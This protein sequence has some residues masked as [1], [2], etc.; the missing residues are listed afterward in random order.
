MRRQKG[1]KRKN[2]LDLS[3][4]TRKK[5]LRR[6]LSVSSRSS[7]SLSC[8][9]C[10]SGW[11]EYERL[12]GRTM[13]RVKERRY[14]GKHKS[15]N[16]RSRYRSRSCSS[17]RGSSRSNSFNNEENMMTEVNSRR[18]R[19]VITFAKEIEEDEE[20]EWVKDGNKEVILCD[21]GDYPSSKS[22]DSLDGGAKELIKCQ[23][24]GSNPNIEHDSNDGGRQELIECEYDGSNPTNDPFEKNNLLM[25]ENRSDVSCAEANLGSD[26][27]ES[28]LRQKALENLRKF[29][30]GNQMNPNVPCDQKYGSANKEDG[31]EVDASTQGADQ[32]SLPKVERKSTFSSQ[33]VGENPIGKQSGIESSVAKQDVISPPQGVNRKGNIGAITDKPKLNDVSMGQGSARQESPNAKLVRKDSENDR[34]VET[35][36]NIAK[37]SDN[38]DVKENNACKSS[39]QGT[40]CLNHVSVEH[41]SNAGKDK[42]KDG[43]QFEQKTMS[44]MRGGEMVRVNYSVY[45]PKKAPALGRRQLRR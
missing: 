24:D 9:T 5:K 8:S 11:S 13:K 19:S 15:G 35:S 10:S 45:I 27:L 7:E 20:S 1:S 43:S 14:I 44:V 18:L 42:A 34:D 41:L 26:D 3:K 12:R 33:N 31:P 22:N 25:S 4:K 30:R 6:D 21:Q 29:R 40:S 39:D 2:S 32:T 36:Q 16:K 37:N 23:G 17:C 38:C 28:L